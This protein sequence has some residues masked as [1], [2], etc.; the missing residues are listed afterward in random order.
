[1]PVGLK[2]KRPRWLQLLAERG[3]CGTRGLAERTEKSWSV[4][5]RTAVV[6]AFGDEA[7]KPGSPKKSRGTPGRNQKSQRPRDSAGELKTGRGEGKVNVKNPEWTENG[8]VPVSRS[9]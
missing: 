7:E 5:K 4:K 9:R 3:K 2:K 6:G 8:Q 1:M